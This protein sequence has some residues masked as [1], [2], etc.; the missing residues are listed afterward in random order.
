LEVADLFARDPSPVL[1]E[2]MA[3][4]EDLAG[5]VLLTVSPLLLIFP[6]GLEAGGLAGGS[7]E[8]VETLEGI[9]ANNEVAGAGEAAGVALLT[10]G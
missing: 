3:S 7:V 6:K 10:E 4:G 5:T 9:E 2:F 1:D 8:L